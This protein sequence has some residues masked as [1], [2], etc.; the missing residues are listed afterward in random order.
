MLNSSVRAGLATLAAALLN[1]KIIAAVGF[2]ISPAT[3]TNDFHGFISLTITG[4]TSGATVRIEKFGD[5]NP[6]GVIDPGEFLMQSFAVTDGQRPFIGGVRNLNVPGDED[7][8][9]NGQILVQLPYPGLNDVLDRISMTYLLR[10]SDPGAAFTPI[11]NA[12][13]I[14][15]KIYPQGVTGKVRGAG[16]GLP[17]SQAVVVMFNDATGGGTGTVTD[18]NGD[19]TLYSEAG[20]YGVLAL[21]PGFVTDQSSAFINV[22][23]NSFA[24]KNITNAVA[25]RAISGRLSDAALGTGLPGL[26]VE[27]ESTN[28]LFT[29]TF[30]DAAGNYTFPVNAGEWRVKV[31][32]ESGLAQ[33]GYVRLQNG[34]NTNTS[35][36]SVSNVNFQFSKATALI[37]GTVRD[38]LTNPVPDV[39]VEAQ[40]Q[41]GVYDASGKSRANGQYSIGIFAGDWNVS[42][43]SERLAARGFIGQGASVSLTNGQALLHD[44]ALQR[45]TA[46]LR[47]YVYDGSG[48]PLPFT[49]L[50]IQLVPQSGGQS[51][52]TFYPDTAGDGSFDVEVFG[53]NWEIALECSDANNNGLVSPSLSVTVVNGV[54]QNNLAL[55]C[56]NANAQISGTVRDKN[57]LPLMVSLYASATVNGTNYNVCG[58]T[59]MNGNF[60]LN[61]FNGVWQVGISGDISSRG[62]DNPPNQTVTVAAS[63]NASANFTVYPAGTTP[64][65]LSNFRF[66]GGQFQFTLTGSPERM[67]RI[68]ATTNVS[69]PSSWIPLRTN[70]AFG[71]TFDFADT[72]VSSFTRRFYRAVTLF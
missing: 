50:V 31:G 65:R 9:A 18:G 17:L 37:Y 21:R 53:G 32:S 41:S 51:L 8:V 43:D 55:R 66:S 61:V 2:S 49:G 22:G 67:Y 20:N 23:S 48:A 27:A 56:R 52:T 38:D 14:V 45:V 5:I 15:Q 64:A 16:T 11:T 7:G 40:D 13:T 4:L 44:F 1:F 33:L 54:D 62:Y 28:N 47:G 63:G 25:D 10:L 34:I 72:N 39:F 36:G 30:S 3:V 59:D 60:Q 70:T 71:G 12:L 35:A 19:F 24:T 68:E 42:P 46:H 58:D 69:N 57:G 29:I 6:N 26:F